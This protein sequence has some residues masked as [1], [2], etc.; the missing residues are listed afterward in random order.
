[1]DNLLQEE[2]PELFEDEA[3]EVS[4]KITLNII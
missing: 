2:I 3:V 4:K 1:M